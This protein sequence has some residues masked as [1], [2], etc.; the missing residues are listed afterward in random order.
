MKKIGNLSM[1][2]AGVGFLGGY[3][4]GVDR[5]AGRFGPAGAE[6][7]SVAVSGGL[8]AALIYVG[9]LGAWLFSGSLG[10][11]SVSRKVECRSRRS[12][13]VGGVVAAVACRGETL[14]S[15]AALGSFVI[16]AL[17]IRAA[18]WMVA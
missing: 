12:R 10:A 2:L 13:S 8:V 17:G 14:F 16:G 18:L 4:W 1:L 3:L 11:S 15:A 5:W 6:L 7:S 9:V